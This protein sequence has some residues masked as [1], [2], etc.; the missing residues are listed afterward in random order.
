MDVNIAIADQATKR[1]AARTEV[2][3]RARVEMSRQARENSAQYNAAV[4]AVL[5][6]TLHDR[7]RGV[8]ADIDAGERFISLCCS[9]RGGKTYLLGTLIV[10]LMHDLPFGQEIVFVAPTMKR[11]KELIFSEVARV[12]DEFCLPWH[13]VETMG[14]IRTTTGAY[15]RVVGLDK[16]KQIGR[17]ARGGNT[18]AFFSDETQEYAHLLQDFIKAASPALAQSKGIFIAA[19]TP[20]VAQSGFWYDVCKGAAG[21]RSYN[22]SLRDNPHLGRPAEEILREERERMGWD[23][24]HPDYRREWL[25]LWC[26]DSN[27]LVVEFNRVKNLVAEPPGYDIKKWRHFVGVDYGFNDPCAWVVLAA[28]PNSREVFVVHAEKHAG[29]T[30][31]QI[32]DKTYELKVRFSPVAIVGDSASGGKTFISDFNVRYGSKAGVRMRHARKADKAGRI[33]FLNTELRCSRLRLVESASGPLIE[34]IEVLQWADD[35]RTKIL[36]GLSFPDHAFDA[37]LYALG[38]FRAYNHKAAKPEPTAAEMEL[39]SIERRNAAARAAE[40]WG[41][42]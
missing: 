5:I 34:E 2:R 18:R 13:I 3:R 29:F 35:E 27:R 38:E 6:A 11:G 19:G 4:K 23:E 20:G 39:E 16:K 32:A 30:S 21:F 9:R 22:W 31:E 36:E 7:Q 24:N 12:I 37:A 1:Q 17:V 41:T 40:S 14:T 26:R 15:F 42:G 10:I 8:V 33:S 25:G 28:H